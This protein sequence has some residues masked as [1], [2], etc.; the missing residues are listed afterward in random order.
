MIEYCV[1]R[2]EEFVIPLS[3][4]VLGILTKHCECSWLVLHLITISDTPQSVG[5]LWTSDQTEAEPCT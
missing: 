4:R 5:L 3:C 2:E 1:L